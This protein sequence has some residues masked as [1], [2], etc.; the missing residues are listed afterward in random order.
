[1]NRFI[2]LLG[3][4]LIIVGLLPGQLLALTCTDLDGAYIYSQEATPVYLGFFGSQF[5]ADSIMNEFGTY[6]SQF[7]SLSVRNEFGTYGSSFS[8]YSANNNLTSTPPRIF[9]NGALIGYLTT[10]SLIVGGV[11]LADIDSSCTFYSTSPKTE[12][13]PPPAPSSVNASDGTFTD[14]IQ[15]SWDGVSG[16]LGYHVYYSETL[17]GTKYHIDET[18][19]TS[20]NIVGATPGTV[21]YFW[22]SAYNAYSEGD[23]GGPDSGYMASLPLTTYT[24]SVSKAGNGSG[25]ITS[26]PAGINC[27]VDCQEDYEDNTVVTLTAVPDGNSTFSGWS[28]ACSGVGACQI[29]IDAAKSVTATFNLWDDPENKAMPWIPLLLL[30]GE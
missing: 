29:T 10:N 20:M 8:T 7:N 4:L 1:M 15:V 5:A 12:P 2:L 24:L 22:V 6:G 9:K 18:V 16:A 11:S 14:I 26:S 17:D 28:G 21:Y 19:N 3:S 23:L 25:T 30:D 13:L 27:G